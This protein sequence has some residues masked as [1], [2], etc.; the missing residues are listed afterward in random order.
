MNLIS[1]KYWHSERPLTASNVL[2]AG[3]YHQIAVT[4]GSGGLEIWVDGTRVANDPTITNGIDGNHEPWV[5]GA[6]THTSTAGGTLD[7]LTHYFDGRISEFSIFDTQLDTTAI[8]DMYD[9]GVNGHD[10]SAPGSQTAD[11]DMIGGT[12]GNDTISGNNG[13][14]FLHGGDGDDTIDGGSHDDVMSGGAGTDTADYSGF[15]AGATVNLETGTATDGGGGTDTLSGFENVLGTN[16]DDTITGN[17]ADNVLTGNA[18]ND[19]LH[20]QDGDDTLIGGAGN[21]TL[22]GGAGDDL[23]QGGSGDDILTGGAG[24]DTVTYDGAANGVTANLATGTATDGSG[25]TDT[26]TSIENLIG[27]AN[28]DTFTGNGSINELTGGD[29]SDR[30]IMGEGGTMDTVHGGAG[31]MGG[32][33]DTLQLMNTDASS[34]SAGWTVQLTT[35][36]VAGDDGSTMTLTDDAAGTI[37]LDDGSQ[38]AFDGLERIEY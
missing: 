18:G 25:N 37:T 9:A 35:G 3:T 36:S 6:A 2:T 11:A 23:L 13:D 17:E 16:A 29:G 4:F 12:A 22:T 21:D 24:I 8:N 1:T 20:G 30:F 7:D 26:L 31:G 38:I 19:A 28:N 15:G 14:D 10:L 34:V 5:L 27:S 33:T 32:W